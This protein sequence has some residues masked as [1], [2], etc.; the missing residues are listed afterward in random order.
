MGGGYMSVYVQKFKAHKTHE[1]K[2]AF[3]SLT[4]KT[5]V[6]RDMEVNGDG[7]TAGGVW[8]IWGAE[9]GRQTRTD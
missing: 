8:G 9:G 4:S 6:K 5:K 2:T 1:R 7:W 3:C